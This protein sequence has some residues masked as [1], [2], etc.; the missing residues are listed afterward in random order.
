MRE[1]QAGKADKHMHVRAFLAVHFC[2]FCSLFL[3][4]L[5]FL[6]AT[7]LLKEPVYYS[8]SFARI[9]STCLPLSLCVC[10]SSMRRTFCGS[11]IIGTLTHTHT[12]AQTEKL[13]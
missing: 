10:V 1:Q 12:H 8:A 7:Q 9:F 5:L 2:C 13:M 4:L 3:F 6:S 11:K